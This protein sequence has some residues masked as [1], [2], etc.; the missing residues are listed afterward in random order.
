[1]YVEIDNDL[2]EILEQ[3]MRLDETQDEVVNRLL[4]DALERTSSPPNDRK[5]S[6]QSRT[7]VA[8]QISDLL[9]AGFIKAGDEVEYRER[10]RGVVHKGHITADGAVATDGRPPSS[11]SSALGHLVGYSVNGWK[12]WV[13]VKSGE[14]LS[15]LR[16]RLNS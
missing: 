6:G 9:R 11:P 1:M 16:D 14:R 3:H 7:S 15:V 13:H 8:G 5:P 12:L 2:A 10:R 4:R